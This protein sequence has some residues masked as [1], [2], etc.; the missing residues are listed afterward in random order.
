M[1]K[2]FFLLSLI[3]VIAIF[4]GC[5]N[6]SLLNENSIIIHPRT[7]WGANEPKP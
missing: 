1:L 2:K 5:F 6:K 3:S 7:I 4:A